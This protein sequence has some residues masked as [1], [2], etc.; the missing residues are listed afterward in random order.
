MG[1]PLA[2]GGHVVSLL[3]TLNSINEYRAD[4]MSEDV[5]SYNDGPR[6]CVVLSMP[7]AMASLLTAAPQRA[8][9]L[10]ARHLSQGQGHV[11]KTDQ[12]FVLTQISTHVSPPYTRPASSSPY[13]PAQ[14]RSLAFRPREMSFVSSANECCR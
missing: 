13:S 9:E 11:S 3:Y 10:S 1:V 5:F 2:R 14:V 8:M 4:R 12:I 6:V 7:H